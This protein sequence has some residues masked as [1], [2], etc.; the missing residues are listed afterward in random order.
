MNEHPEPETQHA[1]AD[2]EQCV[3]RNRWPAS[4]AGS[5]QSGYKGLRISD[6]T[7]SSAT[8]S[9]VKPCSNLL[10]VLGGREIPSSD[11]P[12]VSYVLYVDHSARL[13]K[14][15]SR[16]LLEAGY[17]VIAVANCR[18]AQ[19]RLMRDPL[20]C[21]AVLEATVTARD[22]DGFLD[23][24]EKDDRLG[25]VPV[26]LLAERQW[27]YKHTMPISYPYALRPYGVQELIEYIHKY[28]AKRMAS[29]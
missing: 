18:E 9:A 10:V 2:Q 23:L 7:Y 14:G 17:E 20:P 26:I 24:R 22:V 8:E 13:R 28:G 4:H 29:E 11:S 15:F 6:K 3:E 21:I 27:L 5:G 1:Q 25:A 12:D 16:N 19:I